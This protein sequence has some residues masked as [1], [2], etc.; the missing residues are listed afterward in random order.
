MQLYKEPL[1]NSN[2][3]LSHELTK[4]IPTMTK[5]FLK[6]E[7]GYTVWS[8]IMTI[9]RYIIV[10]LF[11]AWS[12]NISQYLYT[13]IQYRRGEPATTNNASCVLLHVVSNMAA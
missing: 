10:R 9:Y 5:K 11:Y 3:A 13:H 12:L 6:L 4:T 7:T 8:D 1:P 2:V